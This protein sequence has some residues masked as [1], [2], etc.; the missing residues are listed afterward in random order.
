MLRDLRFGL[1]LLLKQPGFSLIAMLTLALG[2]G[3][4]S[5]VLS[6]IQ[7]VLLTPPPY[8]QPQE[9]MLVTTA[10]ADGQKMDSRRGWPAQQWM[11]WQGQAKSFQGIAAYDWTFNFLIRNDGSQS[12]QG[13]YVTKDYLPLMGLKA[14]AGRGFEPV[15]FG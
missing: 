12:M 1:R 7:G 10:R 8:R 5:A 13:M 2:I 15:D 11:E 9:L 3:A 4:T 14:V 6:L